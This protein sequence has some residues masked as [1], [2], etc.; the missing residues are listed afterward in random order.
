MAKYE[1]LV[2]PF[3]GK[4]KGSGTADE[5]SAQLQAAISAQAGQGWE[6]ITLNDVGIEIAPGCLGSLMGK[7]KTYARYDQL[8]FKRGV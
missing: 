6:F 8:I 5:V 1:Y 7:E 4:I 3:V 2:I